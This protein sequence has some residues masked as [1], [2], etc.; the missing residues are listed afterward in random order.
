MELIQ[1]IAEMQKITIGARIRGKSVG[2]VPTMG[3]LHKGHLSLVRLARREADFLVV[4]IFVNP[5]QF[6]E[7]E[8][9]ESYPRD[10]ERDTRLLDREGVDAVFSPAVEEMYPR[11]YS[12]YVE[13]ED[14]TSVLCG[15]SRPG[16]FRGVTTVV[17][18]LFNAVRPHFAVFGEKDFQQAI[19]IRR[20]VRDLN[21]GVRIVLG[22]IVRDE[23]G[24]ALSSRNTYLTGAEREEARVIYRSLLEAR[25][26]VREGNTD[27]GEV[28]SAVR[29]MINAKRAGAVEYVKAVHP[30][31]LTEL[32]VIDREAVIA[33]AARFGRARL[34]D[35]IRVGERS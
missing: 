5:T 29:D 3:Y 23:D 12:T 8:D 31:T 33:V 32:S 28:T 20:M 18:K 21:M 14:L 27:A 25:R 7:G 13:V 24:L 26:M 19:V 35:N 11:D 22:P 34:I 16:H 4:S 1:D 2:L 15:R 9:Y 10:A 6:V 30:E 17:A